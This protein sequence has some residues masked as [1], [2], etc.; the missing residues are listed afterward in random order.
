MEKIITRLKEHNIWVQTI[1]KQGTKLILDEEDLRNIDF[2]KYSVDQASILE[3]NLSNLT[4]IN[5]DFYRSLLCLSSFKQTTINNCDFGKS[6]IRYCDFRNSVI[7]KSR[8][9]DADLWNTKFTNAKITQCN[10]IAAFCPETNFQNATLENINF[11]W[12]YFEQ[13][14]FKNTKLKNI[15]GIDSIHFVSINIGTVKEPIILEDK[16]AKEWFINKCE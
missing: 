6:D 8:F 15:T 11:E 1:G 16:Q 14:L 4:L 2:S 9:S 13:V 3:C 7:N 10:F 5:V 12:A